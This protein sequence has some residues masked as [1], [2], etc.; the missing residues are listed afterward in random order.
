MKNRRDGK[1]FIQLLIFT[2]NF[3]FKQILNN[4]AP[5]IFVAETTV[6][7]AGLSGAA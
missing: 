2:D 6:V 5:R 3:Y 4:S 7:S 1:I